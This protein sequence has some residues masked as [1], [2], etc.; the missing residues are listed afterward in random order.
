M[1]DADDIFYFR[2][3]AAAEFALAR[4]AASL[5]AARA[6]RQLGLLHLERARDLGASLFQ[7]SLRA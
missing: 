1:G 7:P 5:R 6:H 2:G 4:S 3:R